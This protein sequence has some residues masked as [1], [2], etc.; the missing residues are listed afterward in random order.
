MPFA[1]A[2]LARGDGVLAA[3]PLVKPPPWNSRTRGALAEPERGLW[4]E[5][6]KSHSVLSAAESAAAVNLRYL[7]YTRG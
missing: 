6:K 4:P 1:S 7:P 5:G 3:P 2:A